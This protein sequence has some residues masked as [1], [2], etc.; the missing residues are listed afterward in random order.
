MAKT[1]GTAAKMTKKLYEL[2]A[3][4]PESRNGETPTLKDLE[5]VLAAVREAVF[6]ILLKNI[7][8]AKLVTVQRDCIAAMDGLQVAL[9]E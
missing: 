6:G 1:S 8:A 2:A 9:F 4:F 5:D 3:A 7:P